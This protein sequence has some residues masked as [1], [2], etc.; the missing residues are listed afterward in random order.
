[1]IFNTISMEHVAGV[2][3]VLIST[4]LSIIYYHHKNKTI[5][6]QH[7]SITTKIVSDNVSCSKALREFMSFNPSTLGLDC[8]W[9][10]KNKISLLQL[11][12]EKMI[13]LIRIHKLKTIPIELIGL[14]NNNTIIKCGVG[15][16]GDAAKLRH[17]YNID[18][19]GC[20]DMN[21]IFDLIPNNNTLLTDAYGYL[22]SPNEL[23]GITFG[24]NKFSQILLK[25]SMKYKHKKISSSNWENNIL[26]KKQR[27][28]AADDAL[29]GYKL[30]QKAMELSNI[31]DDYLDFC[32]G[33]IDIHHYNKKHSTDNCIKKVKIR[34]NIPKKQN[35]NNTNDT[36]RKTQ[37]K[38]KAFFDNCKILKPN[39]EILSCCST[40]GMR[41]YIK[42]GLAEVIDDK[43]VKLTFE[44]KIRGLSFDKYHQAVKKSQCFV[45]GKE[46]NL[47]K[48]AVVPECYRQFIDE[49]YNNK[50]WRIHDHIP[51]CVYCHRQATCS[52]D[53]IR[54]ELCNKYKVPHFLVQKKSEDYQRL[55]KAKKA[56]WAL[57]KK[58]TIPKERK[59]ILLQNIC[60]FY[61]LEYNV[62]YC[63][64]EKKE[65][66]KN[67]ENEYDDLIELKS[68]ENETSNNVLKTYI[69]KLNE[70][71]KESIDRKQ[72][73]IHS[74]SLVEI[75]K[76][77]HIG[78]IEM[79][80]QA[81]VD[82]M[83][84]RFLPDI[85]SVSNAH[86]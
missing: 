57:A 19:F 64:N 3:V 27:H 45:C 65:N 59:V 26:T 31:K 16:Y 54:N 11:A 7:D 47:C 2:I 25:Q 68:E 12:H 17:D 1:M 9:V 46:D 77:N 38:S 42:K 58:N 71:E 36:P 43:T 51:L 50:A 34:S 5:S 53:M 84:P 10:G 37:G 32:Y 15:I 56:A 81:F 18:T 55:F 66:E 69:N 44:P 72:W 21:D 14:L 74:Q 79:W 6:F 78:F 30:F 67:I 61:G 40:K 39:G 49:K 22:P 48:F 82:N 83:K 23:K 76:D 73:R 70:T 13:L 35:K 63:K 41:W 75:F 33:R 29:I 20:V 8:E 86:M 85:W 4:I 62:I 52:Q 24:L 60:D 80:R 28:Y